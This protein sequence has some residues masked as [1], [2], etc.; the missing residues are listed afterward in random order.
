MSYSIIRTNIKKEGSEKNKMFNN[1]IWV[2][3]LLKIF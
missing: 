2:L 1:I 3:V